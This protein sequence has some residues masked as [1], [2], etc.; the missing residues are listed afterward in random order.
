MGK[1]AKAATTPIKQA[2]KT[3]SK[4]AY[5]DILNRLK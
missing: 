4:K 1:V 3:G 2:A 5:I